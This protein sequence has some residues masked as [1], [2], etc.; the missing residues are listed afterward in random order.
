MILTNRKFSFKF[1]STYDGNH[2]FQNTEPKLLNYRDFK[3]FSPQVFEDDLSE[4]LIGCGDSYDKFENI[5]TSKLN[6]HAPKK[7]EWV[8]GNHKPHINKELRK[9]IMK[10]SR[11]KNKANKT[12]KPID[13]S[14]FKKQ[15][16]YVVNL[17]KQAK[18]EYFS[19]YNSTDSKPFWVNCKPFFSN[20]Y[21]KA[22]T[23]IVLNGNGDLILKNE[24]IAKTFNYY[25]GAI[26]DNLDLHHWEG[27][28][29]SPSNTSDKINDIIKNYEKHQRG[30]EVYRG[31]GNFSFRP[32]SVEEVKKIIQDLKTNKAAGGEIPTKI[33]KECEFTFDVLTK[34]INK[35]IETG[36]FPDSLKLANVAP[37]FKKV[38]SLDKSNYR[39]VSIL[40][41]LLK[42]YEKV[43]Y[44]Q[45]SDYSNS[46][47]NN[48][49]CGFRKAHST[50]HALFKLLQS[51]EQVLDN[52]GFIGTILMDLSKAYDC[53]PHNLLIAKLEYYGVDKAS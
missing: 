53:I 19:S 33:L 9:A 10:R 41:L 32:V 35:S 24:E 12:K 30:I 7:R 40:P 13:I 44:N 18:F 25:S 6:K 11:L 34:H 47:L 1:T 51:W 2:C 29:S 38:D 48:V 27:K 8:R 50:Q 31:I 28:T 22:D 26:V 52:G 4:A 5:F 42:V 23:D 20:K 49:L 37:V 17:N 14:N 3:R 43:I 36:Y 46:F 39:P 16:N 21:R 15:R 45:L